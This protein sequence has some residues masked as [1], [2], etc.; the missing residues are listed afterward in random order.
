MFTDEQIKLWESAAHRP[1]TAHLKLT[2]S[3]M[4]ALLARLEAAEKALL[5]SYESDQDLKEAWRKSA[6][7]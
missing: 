2:P 4:L 5:S 7:K 1:T 6:G 3:A